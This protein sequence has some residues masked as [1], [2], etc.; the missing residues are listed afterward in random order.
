MMQPAATREQTAKD[1]IESFFGAAAQSN[2]D[3]VETDWSTETTISGCISPLPVG[4][5]TSYGSA[6]R[7]PEGNIHWAGTE[8]SEIWMGYMDGAIRSGDRV[9]QEIIPLTTGVDSLLN[10]VGIKIFPNP[11]VDYF[12]VEV[13]S[14]G[15]TVSVRDMQ[16]RLIKERAVTSLG[17]TQIKMKGQAK[18]IYL[19]NIQNGS[20][21][22][23][24]K[25]AKTK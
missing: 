7:A 21:V 3:Y 22:R 17:N 13:P 10:E 15:W 2:I 24:V 9:A 18:G 20:K 14:E 4:V 6:L 12:T 1:E 8:T 5:L 16:G 25:I 23:S 19:V 11:F